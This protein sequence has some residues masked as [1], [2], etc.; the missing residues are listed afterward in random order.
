MIDLPT[1]ALIGMVHLPALPGSPLHLLSMPD[2]IEHAVTDAR[3]LTEAGFDALLIENYGDRP[4]HAENVEPATLAAMT[5]VADRI[6]VAT[7]RPIGINVLRNDARSALGIAAAAGASFIRVNVHTGVSATD[8]GLLTGRADRT[9]RYRKLLGA[10][11]AIFADVHVKHATPISTPDLA[12]A[13]RE[14]AYRGLADALVV[15]GPATGAPVDPQDVRLVCEAVPD[16][17]VYVGSGATV[18]TIG[19]LLPM[20]HGV[21]VGTALK[22]GGDLAAPIDSSRARAFVRAA[23]R[24]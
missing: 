13:A 8:Q 4:F 12:Q 15:S 24:A 6:R 2:I 20:C 19:I 14:T 11:V 17:R 22:A 3:L 18:E 23:G 21:I 5:V 7:G 9:L 1:P 10:R 16:R